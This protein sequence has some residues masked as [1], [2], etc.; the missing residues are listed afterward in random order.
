MPHGSS[1]AEFEG[2]LAERGFSVGPLALPDLVAAHDFTRL[3]DVGARDWRMPAD[4]RIIDAS[5]CDPDRRRHLRG[6]F[7]PCPDPEMAVMRSPNKDIQP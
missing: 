4:L 2:M 1:V 5:T 3:A 6:A 7:R